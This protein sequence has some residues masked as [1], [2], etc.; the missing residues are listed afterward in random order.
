MSR[1]VRR[2]RQAASASAAAA[3]AGRRLGRGDL[4]WLLLDRIEAGPIHGYGLIAHIE[5][6]SAGRYR[7]SPGAV[8][9]LLTQLQAEGLIESWSE[10]GR[11]HYRLTAAGSACLAA[12]A[13]A[14]DAAH[15]HAADL[16]RQRRSRTRLPPPVRAAM[17]RLRQALTRPGHPWNTETS[18]QAVAVL[19]QAVRALAPG[20][21][22]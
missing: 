10:H 19:E 22:P 2:H 9:P 21:A 7:P 14:R 17:D 11:R 16:L 8:Y 6:L 5:A 18:A 12:Q 13:A 4:R 3:A 20:H 1:P 15:A